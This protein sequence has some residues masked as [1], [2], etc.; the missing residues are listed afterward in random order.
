MVERKWMPR[1][2]IPSPLHEKKLFLLLAKKTM[3]GRRAFSE[4]IKVK[5][6]DRQIGLYEKKNSPI[7]KTDD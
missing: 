6:S 7:S 3:L 5:S 1:I 4:T 2:H